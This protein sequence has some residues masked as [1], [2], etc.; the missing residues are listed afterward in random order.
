MPTP[1]TGNRN[2]ELPDVTDRFEANERQ[3][4]ERELKIDDYLRQLGEEVA[5]NPLENQAG[6][7]RQGDRYINGKL[8]EYKTLQPGA[9]PKTIYN[10]VDD[11]ARKGGQAPNIIIDV[12]GTDLTREQVI[13]GLD[14]VQR[15]P[16]L[17]TKID[18]V[19]VI[20]NGFDESRDIRMHNAP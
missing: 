15:S 17:Q 1:D 20:G 3:K 11:S 4:R 7:G 6:Q 13:E 9:V 19:R 10:R 5:E 12:R 2:P 18:N 16:Y 8:T 14:S